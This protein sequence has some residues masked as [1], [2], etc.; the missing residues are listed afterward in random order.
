L[1]ELGIILIG[2]GLIV[3]VAA[4][5]MIN[6]TKKVVKK[7]TFLNGDNDLKEP[8]RVATRTEREFTEMVKKSMGVLYIVGITCVLL[9]I[10]LIAFR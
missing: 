8:D 2:T 1:T 6:S 9:G 10:L 3:I 4:K 7:S 5:A